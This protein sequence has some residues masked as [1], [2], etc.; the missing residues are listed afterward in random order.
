[1][2][3]VILPD[4]QADLLD[5]QDYMLGRWTPELWLAAEQDIFDQLAQVDSGF[6]TGPVVPLL[7]SVGMTDYR[8]VLSSHHRILYRQI[9]GKTYLYAVAG[10]TQDFQTLLLRRLFRR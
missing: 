1:M 5:L 8:T 7:A 4:A 10:Q 9:D 6:I 2:A 3:I